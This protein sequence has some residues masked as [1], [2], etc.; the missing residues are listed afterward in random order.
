MF[1][2]LGVGS[3]RWSFAWKND[4]IADGRGELETNV[5]I[6]SPEYVQGMLLSVLS[7]WQTSYEGCDHSTRAI[8]IETKLQLFIDLGDGCQTKKWGLC[9]SRTVGI[10]SSFANSREAKTHLGEGR[11]TIRSIAAHGRGPKSTE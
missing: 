9:S 3:G 2:R 7:P 10:K 4:E 8:E 1:A 5:F 6:S 11:A